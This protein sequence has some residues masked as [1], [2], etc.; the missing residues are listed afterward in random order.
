MS[1]FF[2]AVNKLALLPRTFSLPRSSFIQDK[3]VVDT[4]F[5]IHLMLCYT[6]EHSFVT[7]NVSSLEHR[8]KNY[9]VWSLQRGPGPDIYFSNGYFVTLLW[10][11]VVS[12]ESLPP[13]VIIKITNLLTLLVY[14]RKAIGGNFVTFSDGK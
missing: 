11:T 7:S 6:F 10:P 8:N 12:N 1:N 14:P 5:L 2:W 13:Q 3:K 9:V 4:W